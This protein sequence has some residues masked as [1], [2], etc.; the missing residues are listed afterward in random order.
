MDIEIRKAQPDDVLEIQEVLYET[1]LATYPNKNY[2]I[3]RECIEERFKNRR[4]SNWIRKRKEY[5]THLP[6]YEC[7]FVALIDGKIIGVCRAEAGHTSNW[8]RA[9]Y[10]LPSCQRQGI[11]KALWLRAKQFLDPG[12]VTRVL[13]ASY[14][15]QAIRFYHKQG[16]IESSR[17]AEAFKIKTGV[18]IPQIELI[19]KSDV[20]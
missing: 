15:E 8:L 7:Y 11:G 14:N 19:R 16:F 3:T 5:V 10:V 17:F 1:W 20:Y 13:V 18:E 9:L 2:G 12:K 6:T 4:E